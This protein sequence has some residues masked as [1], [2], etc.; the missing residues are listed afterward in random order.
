MQIKTFFDKRTYTLTYVVFDEDTRDAVVID[1]VLDYD[2]VGSK[3]WTE[4]ADEVAAFV[5]AEG[6]NVHHILE[7]HAHADHISGAQYLKEKFG[8]ANSVIGKDITEVQSIFKT[9]FDLPD[10]FPTD[11]SQFDLLVEEGDTLAAGALKIEV[12]AT[13]GHTP[14]CL[15]YKID[16][17]VFTGDALFMPDVGAGRCDFP[18][19]SATDLYHS[20]HDKLYA[21]PA[22]TRVFVGH[23]YPEGRQR[24]VEYETTIA[25]QREHNVAISAGRDKD[26]FVAWREARDRSLSAP[27]LLFQSVQV[28]IDAGQLPAPHRNEMRYFRIPMNVFRPDPDPDGMELR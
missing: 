20:V 9:F 25:E 28:N 16:D 23:D 5:A 10:V 21:L 2:P 3:I 12:I 18:G 8:G 19:G 11:G 24:D 4:S 26:D 17:A 6:L 13:P 22:E 1:P 14:A 15:T 27:R 7:T